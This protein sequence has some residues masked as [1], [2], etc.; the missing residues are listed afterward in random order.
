MSAGN[1]FLKLALKKSKSEAMQYM[2]KDCMA[3]DFF[4]FIR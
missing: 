4:C 2:E 1:K 3:S